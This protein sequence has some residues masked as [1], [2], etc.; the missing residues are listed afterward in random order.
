MNTLIKLCSIAVVVLFFALPTSA[1]A[2]ACHTGTPRVH[3]VDTL[4][5]GGPML[6]CTQS[7]VCDTGFHSRGTLANGDP[8]CVRNVRGDTNGDGVVD[9][10]IYPNVCVDGAVRVGRNGCG[11]PP[12]P[13]GERPR[14]LVPTFISGADR[15]AE[16]LP[17]NGQ[18]QMCIIYDPL[19]GGMAPSAPNRVLV[20]AIDQNLRILCG[21]AAGA[22][23]EEVTAGCTETRALIDSIRNLRPGSV[24][25]HYGDRN[26]TI[27]EFVDELL[28]PKFGEIEQR[29]S[30]LEGRVSELE[31]EVHDDIVPRIEALESRPAGS[32]TLRLLADET[33][34][35]LGA[36][37][38]LGFLLSGPATGAGAAS[39]ELVFRFGESHVGLYA[40][41]EFGAQETARGVGGS[42]YLSGGAGLTFFAGGR[43]STTVSFGLFAEDF[44][45][46]W[47]DD[48]HGVMGSEI[49]VSLGA[50]VSASIPLSD[51]VRLRLGL[52]LAY[53]ER[54]SIVNDTF[55][56]T[57]GVY[58][59][60]SIGLEFQP[61]L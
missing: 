33:H 13:V 2:N 60:P 36:V 47:G 42:L 15:R 1:S 17:A 18:A 51:T 37:G 55:T 39:G 26:Y 46:P 38:R 25:I 54:S 7:C 23:A 41:I 3:T 21:A 44:L 53:G 40:R 8:D 10:R 24:T 27:Q 48:P 12:A 9:V 16:G 19:A 14:R 61:D 20:D 56:T 58:L 28:V 49:G 50:E 35:R 57:G 5:C 45:E 52:A 31:T 22:D 32:N 43:H 30:A 11:C 6:D 29:L 59:A 4:V 34:V